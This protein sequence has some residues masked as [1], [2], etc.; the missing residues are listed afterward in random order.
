MKN[1]FKGGF[2]FIEILIVLA[3]VCF[4][5]Y[6]IMNLY[7]KKGPVINKETEKALSEQGIDTANY[8]TIT[9]STRE[10]IE[11]IQTQHFKELEGVK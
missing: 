3:I 8:K 11:G 4:I 5:F 2:G 1:E 7:F 6:K 9:D 10:K